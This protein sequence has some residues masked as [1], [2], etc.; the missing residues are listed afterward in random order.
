MRMNSGASS[1]A[2]VLRHFADV[3]S[4]SV[5]GMAETP[6]FSCSNSNDVIE[7]TICGSQT[8]MKADHDLSDAYA[9]AAQSGA[10][11]PELLKTDQVQ[12][13]A[14][15]DDDA[16]QFLSDS[17]SAKDDVEKPLITSYQTRIEFL[18]SRAEKREPASAA[19]KTIFCALSAL[20]QQDRRWSSPAMSMLEALDQSPSIPM[21]RKP[22]R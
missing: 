13:L 21:A 7:K 15:R 3:E 5:V 9:A 17:E 12:W 1:S 14:E 4:C 10:A 6:G 2:Q 18:H 11:P 22:H 8:L 20:Y 16:W 19:M